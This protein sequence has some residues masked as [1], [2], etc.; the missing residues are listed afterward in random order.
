MA[1]KKC[2][3]AATFGLPE[4]N[5]AT[6]M[7]PSPANVPLAQPTPQK[8]LKNP[9]V[10]ILSDY[11]SVPGP[12]F[13]SKFPSCP[14]PDGSKPLTEVDVVEFER[15]FRKVNPLLNDLEREEFDSVLNSLR[16]G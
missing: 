9:E 3:S 12:E 2:V 15:L 4:H 14:I 13:W 6:W 1:P 5:L 11:K 16:F 7:D 10:P 8:P